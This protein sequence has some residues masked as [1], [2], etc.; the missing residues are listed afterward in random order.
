MTRGP[1]V[2]VVI[3]NY[4]TAA[5][6]LRCAT[7]LRRST[8]RAIQM[9]VVDNASGS[10]EVGRLEHHLG[11]AV[12]IIEAPANIGYAAGNNIGIRHALEND[13][14]FVW[15]LNPDTEVDPSTLQLLIDGLHNLPDAGYIGSLNVYGGSAPPRVQFAGGRIL[16]ENGAATESI[17]L[18]RPLESITQREP[19][20]VDYAAG[21]SMLVRRS[22]FEQVGLLPEQYFMYFEETDHQV[23]A[24]KIG[25][26]SA[27]HPKAIV[28]HHQ[29]STGPIP[30]PYYVYYYIRSRFRFARTHTDFTIAEIEHHSAAFIN[31]WR[32]RV[33]DRSPSWLDTYD[34]L[35][36][37][38]VEDGI[39]GLTG[40]RAEVHGI[41]RPVV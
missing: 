20:F 26:R 24:A 15:I 14:D 27:V 18:G 4:R 31:G 13:A 21:T 17:A 34:R 32:S 5:H 9:I 10:D 38:A 37:W 30:A 7:S 28:R 3:L 22:V 19:Y 16:W 2:F 23:R 36:E 39:A 8:N 35:V 33:E 12:R 6:T 29:Q 40:A 41:E 1:R 11:P 25:W